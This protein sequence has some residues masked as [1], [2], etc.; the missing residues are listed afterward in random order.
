MVSMSNK[1]NYQQILPFIYSSALSIFK[2]TCLNSVDTDQTVP[3][4][5][6]DLGLQYILWCMGMFFCCFYTKGNNS[7]KWSIWSS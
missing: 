5:P 2:Q 4:C 3:Y 7:S 6:V 1:K